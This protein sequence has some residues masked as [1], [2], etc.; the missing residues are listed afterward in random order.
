MKDSLNLFGPITPQEHDLNVQYY[1]KRRA[2]HRR[3]RRQKMER[4]I[5]EVLLGLITLGIWP[6]ARV[7]YRWFT[8]ASNHADALRKAA[9]IDYDE[10]AIR[11]I[12]D[13]SNTGF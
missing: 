4:V 2:H 12:W 1:L 13:P 11:K 8:K 5:L 3:Q 6:L 7:C 10:T 9:R